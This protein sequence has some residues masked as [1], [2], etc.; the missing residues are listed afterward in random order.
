MNDVAKLS[1]TIIAKSDQLNGDDLIA[2]PVTVTV[3]GVKRGSDDQ[4]V[5]MEIDGGHQ[6][7]KPCKSMRRVLI[8]AWGDDGRA[9]VGRSMTLYCDPEVMY[10]GVKV[11]GIRISHLSHIDAPEL[12]VSMNVKKGRKGVVSVKRLALQVYPADRFAAEFPKMLAAIASGKS[13]PEK[14]IAHC[15]KTA[16]LSAEQKAQIA[17]AVPAVSGNDDEVF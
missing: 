17:A 7:Y 2:G 9:W 16:P 12:S 5:V 13:T 3:R 1:D 6:P 15:E 4:P 10:G 14:I 8:A 11:G